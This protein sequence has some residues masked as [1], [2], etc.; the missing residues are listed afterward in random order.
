MIKPLQQGAQL[1][2]DIRQDATPPDGFRM[3]W[4]GQ[5]GFLIQ[6]SSRHCLLDPYLSDSLTVKYAQTDKPHTRMS[7]LVIDPRQLDMVD[8]A[9]SSHNHTDHLDAH[10][11]GPLRAANPNMALIIPEANRSFVQ[12]RLDCGMDWPVGLSDGAE[13]TVKGFNFIGIPASHE[14]LD[15]DTRGCHKYMGYVIKFGKWTVYHSGDTLLF[16]G[17]LERLRPWNVDVAMLPI[18]GRDPVRRVAGNLNGPQAARL[19]YDIGAKIVIPCHYDMF[20]FNTASP[21]AFEKACNALDQP[22]CVMALG[23]CFSSQEM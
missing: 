13:A 8:V 19:A 11:L 20:T 5:S 10:T 16:D 18:N 3:W 6:W 7:E 12:E 14:N 1:L 17:L 9:S 21:D 22:Y 4:L 23:Q 15:T 2:K